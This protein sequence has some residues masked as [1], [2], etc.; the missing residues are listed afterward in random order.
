MLAEAQV[1]DLHQAELEARKQRAVF[2]I[3]RLV[4]F[5]QRPPWLTAQ[6]LSHYVAHG[7]GVEAAIKEVAK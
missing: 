2:V 7:K 3:G 4:A 1:L 5:G 6:L